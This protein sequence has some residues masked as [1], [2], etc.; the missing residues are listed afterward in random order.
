MTGTFI[1]QRQFDEI[2]ACMA[3]IETT[4]GVVGEFTQAAELGKL[5]VTPPPYVEMREGASQARL[6]KLKTD[7]GFYRLMTGHL[8][9]VGRFSQYLDSYVTALS[10]VEKRRSVSH[11]SSVA[12][13]ASLHPASG[14]EPITDCLELL[15]YHQEWVCAFS[16]ICHVST[17]GHQKV[18][19]AIYQVLPRVFDFM[20]VHL[21][22]ANAQ[23]PAPDHLN[24]ARDRWHMTR[25]HYLSG[26]GAAANFMAQYQRINYLLGQANDSFADIENVA[27]LSRLV[28]GMRLI[29]VEL[30]QV[31]RLCSEMAALRTS[32]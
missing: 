9:E 6:W 20:S 30:K 12:V 29:M 22:A 32:R 8:E 21:Q 7:P 27:T 31:Q 13:P 11:L 24:L 14:N 19:E 1:T 3:F 26:M 15:Q 4:P 25:G 5:G 17:P 2:D 28:A 18:R 10:A 16:E 23:R